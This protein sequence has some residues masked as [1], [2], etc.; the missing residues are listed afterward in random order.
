MKRQELPFLLIAAMTLWLSRGPSHAG[1]CGSSSY[2]DLGALRPVNGT[3]ARMRY[4]DAYGSSWGNAERE[5]FRFLFPYWDDDPAGMDVLWRFSHEGLSRVAAPSTQAL[6]DAVAVGDWT[7]AT[8]AAHDVIDAVLELPPVLAAEHHELFDRAVEVVELAPELSK[9]PVSVAQDYL[10]Q[11]NAA[12]WPPVL[13]RADEAR[14]DPEAAMRAGHPREATLDW[15]ALSRDFAHTV[16][17]GWSDAIRKQVP[18]ATWA[19][20]L[21]DTEAWQSKHLTHPLRDVVVL[22]R[23]RI[24]YFAG[25]TGDAWKILVDLLPRRPVRA[26]AEMRY[27]LVMGHP[28]SDAQID[29]LTDPMLITALAAPERINPARWRR[30]WKLSENSPNDSWAHH[31]QER[32]LLAAAKKGAPLSPSFPTL[33]KPPTALWGKLRAAALLEVGLAKA[34][35]AQ[36]ALV[37]SDWEQARLAAQA[38]LKRNRLTDAA[39]LAAL[40]DDTRRYV[41]EVL[42][43]DAELAQ[44]AKS[45]TAALARHARREL[46]I[47]ATTLGRWEEAAKSIESDDPTRAA[48]WRQAHALARDP[49]DDAPV[50]LARL[51]GEHREIFND[52]DYGWYRGVSSRRE[53]LRTTSKRD[54]ARRLTRHLTRSSAN[55]RALVLL[56]SWLEKHQNHAQA[57]STLRE[58]DAHYNR[59]INQG[60]GE[61]YFWSAHTKTAPEIAALRR[62]GKSIRARQ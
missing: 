57:M 52:V 27:L 2:A 17:D 20:L 40:D 5:A 12:S 33:R 22:H 8:T 48:L 9:V 34:A 32:L 21:S 59:L 39:S 30:W 18:E 24:H 56:T 60:G 6:D 1:A 36:L 38:L 11:E 19:R 23:V 41:V 7:A 53:E 42:M 44:L 28:P 54:E 13:A 49:A 3:V 50:R 31:L 61:Y 37:P 16:P 58:A 47:R 29:A 46:G 62:V 26:L 14:S 10:A 51:F 4:P 43:S 35:N 25:T 15:L 45:N 55:W